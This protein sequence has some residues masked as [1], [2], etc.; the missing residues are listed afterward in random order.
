MSHVRVFV[1]LRFYV[2]YKVQL[3]LI[4]TFILYISFALTC[5]LRY[6]K[7]LTGYGGSSSNPTVVSIHEFTLSEAQHQN[8]FS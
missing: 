8:L 7:L 1:I 2:Y 4:Y 6:V 3:E 5:S